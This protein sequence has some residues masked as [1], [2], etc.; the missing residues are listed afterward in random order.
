M[1]N[2]RQV[3]EAAIQTWQPSGDLGTEFDWTTSWVVEFGIIAGWAAHRIDR[4]LT[5]LLLILG[6]VDPCG[7]S[8]CDTRLS[9]PKMPKEWP[10]IFKDLS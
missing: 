8:R 1:M 6:I 10:R 2:E 3:V 7:C 4:A 5:T 9:T